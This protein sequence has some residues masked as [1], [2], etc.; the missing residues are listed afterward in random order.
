MGIAKEVYYGEPGP[1]KPQVGKVTAGVNVKR[2]FEGTKNLARYEKFDSSSTGS[3]QD[4]G[5]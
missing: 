5:K 3:R 1:L 4:K 2:D